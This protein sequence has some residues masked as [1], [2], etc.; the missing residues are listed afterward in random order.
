MQIVST[1]DNLHEILNLFSWK[2]KFKKNIIHAKSPQE[3][4]CMKYQTLFSGEKY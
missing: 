3:A 2:K 4:I 1:R